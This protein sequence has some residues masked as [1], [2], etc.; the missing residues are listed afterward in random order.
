M[1]MNR[2]LDRLACLESINDQLSSEL[3][4]VDHLLREIGFVEGLDSVK[5]A[6]EELVEEQ[7]PEIQEE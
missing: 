2:L 3:Q 5:K 1:H 6:A 4:Y 7:H